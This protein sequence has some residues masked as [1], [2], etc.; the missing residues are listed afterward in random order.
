MRIVVSALLVLLGASACAPPAEP[1]GRS[2]VSGDLKSWTCELFERELSPRGNSLRA[3]GQMRL[4]R[5]LGSSRMN[6][7]A[8]RSTG[9]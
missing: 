1:A 9:C 4:P 7:P 3:S 8:V 2:S 6:G 5:D